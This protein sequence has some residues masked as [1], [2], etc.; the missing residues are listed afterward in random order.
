MTPKTCNRERRTLV[1]MLALAAAALIVSAPV[2]AAADPY[3][4]KPVKLVLW[5]PPGGTIDVLSR[6]IADQLT[7]RWKQPVVV[8]NKPGASGIIASE[9]VARAPADGH[10][11]LVTINTTHINNPVLRSKLPYDA[12][13]DFEP[14]SQ[15][16]SGSVVLIAPAKHPANSVGELVEWARKRGKPLSY[17]SWGVGTSAHLFGSLLQ[18]QTGLPMNHIPYKGEM[19]AITDMLGGR[20]DVTFAG[21]GTARAQ[22]AGGQVKILGLTGPKRIRALPNVST[23][24]EQGFKGFELVGWVAVY[25]PAKTPKPVIAKISAELAEAVRAPEVQTR[26]VDNGFEPVGSTPDQFAA[27]FKAEFPKWADLIKASGAK[28]E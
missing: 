1:S 13:K 4:A 9:H 21:G 14:V 12:V 2:P 7:A 5:F 20:L 25:A 19:P 17:G 8:E 22:A 23:F 18:Q 16:A 26:M 27:L 15:I 11:L 10:T 3:P 6:L 24:A 28:V